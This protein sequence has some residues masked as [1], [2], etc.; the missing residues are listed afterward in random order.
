MD[1]RTASS[2]S[3]G[4]GMSRAGWGGWEDIVG[5]VDWPLGE[6]A[7]ELRCRA[8]WEILLLPTEDEEDGELV[9]EGSLGD[10]WRG[11]AF[12]DAD[13]ERRSAVAPADQDPSE[14]GERRCATRS[15]TTLRPA[16]P[17]TKQCMCAAWLLEREGAG[18]LPFLWKPEWISSNLLAVFSPT[19]TRLLLIITC[20]RLRWR[21]N[22]Q[23][24][25][26]GFCSRKPQN[27]R[28][29]SALVL[30]TAGLS[31]LAPG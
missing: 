11:I 17:R 6:V 31:R 5:G 19:I 25:P 27:F 15:T 30:G 7:E 28:A 13:L 12:K 10:G 8:T 20:P 16:V 24:D 21:R 9:M 4:P 26:A 1:W 3:I 29:Q 22:R 23:V 2:N 14:W 18:G